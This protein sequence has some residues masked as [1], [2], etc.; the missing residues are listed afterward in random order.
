VEQ[1]VPIESLLVAFDLAQPVP[2][3]RVPVGLLSR[4]QKAAE[5]RRLQ[6]EQAM[7][8]AYEAEL[9]L[10]LAED[11]PELPDDHPAAGGGSWAPDGEL[12]GVAGSFSHEL[13]MI[14]NCGR[15][16]ASIRA[17]RAWTYRES[18]P[19]T[20]AALAAGE[21]D[22]PRARALVEVLES[23]EPAVARAVEARL[24]PQAVHLSVGAL[25]RRAVALLLRLDAAAVDARRAA[26]Q[27]CADVRVYPSPREGMATLAAE[28][29]APQAAACHEMLDRLAGMV[30]AD[31]DPRPIGQLRAGV[32]AE[33]IR[34]PWEPGRAVTA[35]LTVLAPLPALA[36]TGAEP[37]EVNGLPITAAQLRELAA[38][39]GALGVRAPAG[40]SLTVAVTDPAGALR[41]TGTGRQLTRPA[42]RGCRQHPAGDCGCPVLDRPPPTDGYRPTA[43]QRLFVHTRD[44][45]CRFPNCGQ[46]V[47]WADLDHVIEHARGGP[48]CC[49]N[50]CC[51]C[52][53]HH[54]LKTRHN[55][56]HF[57]MDDDGVLTVTTPSGITRTTRPPG[58][59]PPPPEPPE[60]RTDDPPHMSDEEDPPPF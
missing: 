49:T 11:T 23:T 59:H 34:R 32:L 15:R 6:A 26:A 16:S 60:P 19:G 27:R 36:G 41:A 53:S 56:W 28:L 3:P 37:G 35:R 33:L 18:L 17:Q 2:S 40:G 1:S 54:R 55:N 31:G 51:L 10:G 58:L 14:L 21:L 48:T 13:S 20:W 24:L 46:R 47:G 4:E 45:A 50:L 22:E 5:L 7:R 44:R 8:A 25:R 30:K 38:D 43:A 42:R 12:P 57:R 52:R 39:L 9:I 29:P